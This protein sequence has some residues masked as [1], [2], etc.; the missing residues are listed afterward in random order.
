MSSSFD[1][2]VQTTISPHNGQAY[3]IETYP[4]SSNLDH[5]LE[6]AEKFAVLVNR[7]APATYDHGPLGHHNL[8][9]ELCN[10][11]GRPA[12]QCWG[13]FRGF[14]Q[15][16]AYMVDIAESYNQPGFS[17]SIKRV[18]LGV[19]LVIA[20]WNYPYLVMI[21]S[22]LPALI[23]G[24]A[25]ILKPS[26]Q[27]PLTAVRFKE[28]LNNAGFPTDLIQVV[29]LSPPLTRY[30]VQHKLVD[31]VVFTGSVAGGKAI[32]TAAVA[33]DGFKGVGLEL[34]GKDPAYVRADA[35]LKDAVI[36]L[37]DGAMYN[38]GQ[39]CCAVERI[40]VHESVYDNFVDE[41]VNETKKLILGDPTNKQTTIGPVISIASAERI[42]QQ[43]SS[44]GNA[45]GRKSTNNRKLVSKGR[46]EETFGPIIGIQ[47]VSSDAEAI[48][49]MNDSEYGLTASIWTKS[50]D[51]F[52]TL[53][54][55]VQAGTI[56]LNRCDSLDPALAW[57]GIKNSGR[58][59]SLSK[60]GYD[61]LT[62]AKS[63]NMRI[64]T[65]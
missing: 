1:L 45:N 35:D 9:E 15:R 46:T 56:F 44:A 17:R 3:H 30:V 4:V 48:E 42:R 33:A 29:H 19:I 47:K 12:D 26:P 10:Q 28:A 37:V 63:I 50:L 39:S 38:A 53:A 43:V 41:Y 16:A 55:Q 61:Q 2:H 52:S 23:A 34:G 20:P 8:A 5:T 58:G 57:T 65:A 25:V 21:N 40:Y 22:V 31:F 64:N 32:E 60:F 18:P 62:R 54:D 7:E 6:S 14:L 51:D 49:L 27:T 24:N 13:E 59:V 36:Q 11:M